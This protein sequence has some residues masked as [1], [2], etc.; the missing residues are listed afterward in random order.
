MGP[1]CVQTV[2]P[3]RFYQISGTNHRLEVLKSAHQHSL[4]S[5]RTFAPLHDLPASRQHKERRLARLEAT[6]ATSVSYATDTTDNLPPYLVTPLMSQ[7]SCTWNSLWKVMPMRQ[8]MP[9]CWGF[10]APGDRLRPRQELGVLESAP[11]ACPQQDGADRWGWPTCMPTGAYV[12]SY[13]NPS[14]SLH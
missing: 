2:A 14:S 13:Q 8:A 12:G 5:L 6:A 10:A 7:A 3:N 4:I 1:H 11:C 9:S